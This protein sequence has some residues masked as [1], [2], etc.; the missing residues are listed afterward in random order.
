MK[1]VFALVIMLLIIV[2]VQAQETM[3]YHNI[4]SAL[5]DKSGN[6][7]KLDLSNK[8]LTTIP[9]DVFKIKNLTELDVSNNRINE[10]SREIK[11]L[12]D[13]VVFSADSTLSHVSKDIL[14]MKNLKQF[15]LSG[16]HGN[17]GKAIGKS[18]VLETAIYL[19]AINDLQ[20]YNEFAQA[21]ESQYM[22]ETESFAVAA[23]VKPWQHTSHAFGF[24]SSSEPNKISNAVSITADQSLKNQ[25]I[26]VTLDLLYVHDYPGTGR[27][28][29]LFD[30][31]GENQIVN[32][33]T[34]PVHYSQTRT[35]QE[36]QFA[37]IVS[38]PI[39]IGLT[40]G[41][42][43]VGFECKTVNVNNENDEKFLGILD[44]K[45]V[46]AGLKL[47][48]TINPV[49]PIVTSLAE[50]IAKQM[51]TRNRNKTIQD[52]A[53]GLDFSTVPTRAKLKEGTYIAVQVDNLAGWNWS[54]W[55]YKAESGVIVSKADTTKT[56]PFNYLVFSISKFVD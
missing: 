19:K 22:I 41:N 50:G 34:Q 2:Q 46:K 1:I 7:I 18:T 24:I 47:V 51:A 27:H 11:N 17:D 21:T 5:K 35:I 16:S 9:I 26:K 15:E 14:Q 13:L 44:S 45:E 29:V 42:E 38:I 4:D 37:A 54:E 10:V 12:R 20:A 30:F 32:S 39:F 40:V 52:F 23:N 3:V 55:E 43:G 48:N 49:V 56:I 28:H 6:Q 8:N 25:R 36:G 53:M 31:K 33:E